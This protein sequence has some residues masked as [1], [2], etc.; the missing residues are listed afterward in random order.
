VAESFHPIKGRRATRRRRSPGLS[1]DEVA[2]RLGVSRPVVVW[3]QQSGVLRPVAVGAGGAVF[4]SAEV[5]SLM[6]AAGAAKWL[7]PE[8]WRWREAVIAAEGLPVPVGG[9][10]DAL[11]WERVGFEVR[12]CRLVGL[13]WGEGVPWV[14]VAAALGLPVSVC[15]AKFR[16]CE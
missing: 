14:D 4:T 6:D 15:Y 16:S 12:A 10:V 13:A 9:A 2:A 8:V 5:E 1:V 11:V 3:L 7:R